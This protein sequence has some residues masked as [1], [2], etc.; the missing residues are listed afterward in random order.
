MGRL[1]LVAHERMAEDH[2]AFL[3]KPC[4]DGV[5]T[6]EVLNHSMEPA[7]LTINQV[8]APV[9]MVR[10]CRWRRA[11]VHGFPGAW[12]P[13]GWVKTQQGMEKRR[14]G[15]GQARYD[16]RLSNLL[17]NDTGMTLPIF[18]QPQAVD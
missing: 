8:N 17:F 14:P 9:N 7:D 4:T 10:F 13:V 1:E 16:D 6:V 12:N 5:N 15:A 18:L 3:G 2:E 11:G